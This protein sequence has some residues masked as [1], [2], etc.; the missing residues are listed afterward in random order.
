VRTSRD[1]PYGTLPGFFRQYELVYVVADERDVI[2]VRTNYRKSPIEPVY[3]FRIAAPIENGRR[4]LLDYMRDIS[5][6]HAHPRFYN[7][8]T[9]NCT[10]MILAHSAVNP[11]HLGYSWKVLVTGYTPEYAYEKGRLDQSLPFAELKRRSRINAVAQA[12]DQAPD[13]SRR[14]RVGLP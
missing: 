11:G 5:V 13:F 2:R 4:V 14:I 8:L 7:T 12:A 6:L 1:R 3:L 10:T 9:T